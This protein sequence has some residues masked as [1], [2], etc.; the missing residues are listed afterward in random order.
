MS[1]FARAT[2]RVGL[3]VQGF[4]ADGGRGVTNEVE[5]LVSSLPYLIGWK[6]DG[7]LDYL[8][9]GATRAVKVMAIDPQLRPTEVKTLTLEVIVS[10]A[11]GGIWGPRP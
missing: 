7:D 4:E 1:R 10:G 3:T 5:Q 2:Y 9:R 6:A 11:S 8:S